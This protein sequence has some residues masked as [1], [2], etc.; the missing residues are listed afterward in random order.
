[1]KKIQF[2]L[3]VLICGVKKDPLSTLSGS[4]AFESCLS[5]VSDFGKFQRGPMQFES[6]YVAYSS[7][8]YKTTDYFH[9]LFVG[10]S[11][12]VYEFCIG[13]LLVFV[14]CWRLTRVDFAGHSVSC[15][16]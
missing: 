12:S 6:C 8:R 9:K 1:M 14:T 11:V 13:H 3:A 7:I 2:D 4:F 15:G 5:V 10:L 16:D